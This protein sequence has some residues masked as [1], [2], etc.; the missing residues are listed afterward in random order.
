[1][2]DNKELDHM[3]MEAGKFQDLQDEDQRKRMVLESENQER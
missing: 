3:I 1:M 2:I